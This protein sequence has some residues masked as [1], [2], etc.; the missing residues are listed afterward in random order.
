MK[1]ENFQSMSPSAPPDLKNKKDTSLSYVWSNVAIGGGGY[2]TGIIYNPKE[3]GLA[4]I[5]TDIGGAYRLDNKLNKWIPLTDHFGGSEWNLIGI[6]SIASD[7]VETNRVYA[8][9]GTYMRYHGAIISSDDYGRT[10]SR[11]DA[12]FSC[13]S[14][15]SGRGAG[16]RMKVDP[17]N[18]NNVYFG[19]R[20]SGL[21]KSQN[22]GKNW[23][24][25]NSF[26][27]LVNS[28]HDD[29]GI[30]IMW[31]E[32]DPITNDIYVAAAAKDD[33]CIY[34]SSDGGAQWSALPVSIPH[35]FPLQAVISDKRVMYLACSDNVGPDIAPKK[36]AVFALKL[37]T[38]ELSDITPDVNDGHFGGYGAIA[39]DP[40]SHETIVVSS[41]GFWHNNGDNIYRSVNGGRTWSALYTR[42]FKNYI[43]DTSDADWIK[44]GNSEAKVGWWISALAV[45]PF[46]SDEVTYGTGASLFTTE[47]ISG[48]DNNTIVKIKFFAYGIEETAVFDIISPP[49]KKNAPQL[50]SI[51]GDLTGFAHTNVN[52]YPDDTHFMKNGLPD[53]IDCAWLSP[54]KAVYT[55]NSK[56]SLCITSDG[57]KN[58]KIIK[59]L[60]EKTS[61][62]KVAI[63]ADGETI[64]WRSSYP[65]CK[66]Y[67]TND[68]GTSWKCCDGLGNDAVIVSDKVNPEKFYAVC[69]RLFYVSSDR[70]SSFSP[71]GAVMPCNPRIK[72]VGDKQG[73]IW[74]TNGNTLMFTE[75]EGKNFKKL[76]NINAIAVGFGARAVNSSYMT[77]YAMGNDFTDKNINPQGYGIFR[78]TDKGENWVRINDDL[79]LFGNLNPSVT[80]DCNIFG[81][82]YFATNGRG[83]IIGDIAE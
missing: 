55:S 18:N 22:F 1:T 39:I 26:P 72:T 32:F 31:I 62:G 51:M 75:D 42:Q 58:W 35:L 4:Y 5:R 20:D 63:S 83:I 59:N 37:D 25:V 78:S 61:G 48:L 3:D 68:S 30:G 28:G 52:Q 77:I 29:C 23:F 41:L 13:G 14:N 19:T 9:C 47:N 49:K 80:G 16:E 46:N 21:W 36:G 79:H 64:V 71:T 15:H 50:Y 66:S 7:P 38:L 70:G 45:N 81:R 24:R 74:I 34:K 8:A 33:S 57:G 54:N 67:V 73:H 27:I 82:V 10:W 69:N 11:F 44:W 76:N 60:P 43:M 17:I 56:A 65:D 12:P 6:E 2:I 40:Q 53:S